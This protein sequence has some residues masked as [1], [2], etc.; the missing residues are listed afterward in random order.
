MKSTPTIPETAIVLAAGRGKRMGALTETLPKPL[1][2][3]EG[4]ALVD[5]VLDR[6]ALVGVKRA[7]VNLHYRGDAIERHLQPRRDIE[8]EF[9]REEAVLETGGGIKKALPLLGESFYAVNADVFWLDGGQHA[10]AR[11]ARKFAD[12]PFDA[13]LLMQRATNAVGYEGPGDFFL[14]P[15]G[16]PRRR[17]ER[18]VAPQV[19]AGVEILHRRLFEGAPEGA[20][21][22]NLLWDRAISRGKL[23]GLV[24]DGEWYHIGTP[25]G[26]AEA[27]QRLNTRRVER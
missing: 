3:I 14:D 8:I 24:H 15:L 16:L 22:I 6:L 21:S 27:S 18:E 12:E 1:I 4:R 11:L 19:F 10:L 23:G 7:V 25:S 17:L 5:H 20:F 9:S 13:I 26:L 2:Q